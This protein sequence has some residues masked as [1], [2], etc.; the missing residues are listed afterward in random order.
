MSEMRIL[1][2]ADLDLRIKI[3]PDEEAIWNDAR[4]NV[5]NLFIKWSKSFP[6]SSPKE[7]LA[8]I[9]LR[10]AHVHVMRRYDDMEMESFLEEFEHEIDKMILNS[11]PQE[12]PEAEQ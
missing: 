3:N 8:M 10:F 12:N 5:N 11:A 7:V 9:A 6:N 2:V 4:D 1:R